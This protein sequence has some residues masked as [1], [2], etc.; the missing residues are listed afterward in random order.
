MK[1]ATDLSQILTTH[2]PHVYKSHE[3]SI[4]MISHRACRVTFKG[5]PFSVPAEEILL[6]ASHYGE[7]TS[8]KVY[9]ETVR[10]GGSVSHTLPCSNRFI[11]MKIHSGKPMRNYYWMTG[12]NQGESGRRITVLHPNQPKQCSA[13]LAFATLLPPL[14]PL[15]SPPTAKGRRETPLDLQ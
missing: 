6:L 9:R 1:N 4:S 5:I 15:G 2:T 14:A 3:I 12:P 11:E 7:L 10:L 8:N 13:A